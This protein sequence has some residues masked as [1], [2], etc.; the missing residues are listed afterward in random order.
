MEKLPHSQNQESQESLEDVMQQE[1]NRV[2]GILHVLDYKILE[3]SASAEELA[4]LN[5]I[6]TNNNSKIVGEIGFHTG[7]SSRAFLTNT[8]VEQIVSFDI[9]E[10]D[11]V[12]A[13]KEII[14]EDFPGKHDLIIGDSKEIVPKYLE[15]NPETKFDTIFIDGGHDFNT[16]WT[17]ILNMKKFAHE[18]TDVIMD[19]LVNN[20]TKPWGIGVRKAWKKA[21]E[22]GVIEQQELWEDG[23]LAEEIGFCTADRAWARGRYIF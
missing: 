12:S 13:A 16:A 2:E 5:T 22:E 4:C 14:D 7:F 1:M 6:V 17:D 9:G 20:P 10:Y 18:D 19:D 11:Y 15:A 21:I 23:V 8:D 3:G